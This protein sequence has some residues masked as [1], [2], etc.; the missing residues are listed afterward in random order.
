[1][2][3]LTPTDVPFSDRAARPRVSIGLP[4][5]NGMPYLPASL[6]SLLAQ[7][8]TNIEIVISD[9]ASDDGTGDYCRSLA[10]R[11]S[12]VSYHHNKVNIGASANF[13]RVVTLS[14]SPL[15][16]WAAHDD[17]YAR[18]FVSR[19][20]AEL[21]AD[22]SVAGCVPAHRVIDENGEVLY[23][24][25]EPA[26]LASPDLEARLRA[27]LW[28]LG[29][30]T[31]YGVW[32][33]DVLLRIGPPLPVWG[34]DVILVWRALFLAPVATI[35]DALT[36]YRVF[37][38]KT[39]DAQISGLTA[40]ES[41]AHFSHVRITK[42]LASAAIEIAPTPSDRETSDRVLRRWV[43]TRYYR[44]LAFADLFVEARRYWDE[45]AHLRAVALL[46]VMAVVSPGRSLD[47]LRRLRKYRH[48]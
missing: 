41:R 11:D 16:A 38:N 19:C 24:R 9:N 44:Q 45:G 35:P 8:E 27:H 1:M 26:Q 13:H 39:V 33:K 5:R 40:M 18:S 48:L 17:L 10:S 28:R 3:E 22:S 42:N 37:R 30:L 23:V 4:V 31:L 2:S 46:A 20:A 6:E 29:K 14:S 47:G 15:F 34:A 12:R 36:D 7:D 43:F 32:R 21:D 25:T